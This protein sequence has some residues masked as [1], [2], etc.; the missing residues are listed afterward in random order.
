MKNK[1]KLL[2]VLA[3]LALCVCTVVTGTLAWLTAETETITNTFSPS[4]IQLTL[5]E[6]GTTDNKK[7]FKMI[8]GQELGKDPKIEVKTDIACYV[9]VKI[10]ETGSVTVGSNN[11]SFD[12]FM[13]YVVDG[14]W[15]SLTDVEGVYYRTVSANGTFSVLQDNEIT[16][17][18]T[19]SSEMM[20]AFYTDGV[21]NTVAAPT[22][23]FTA[24]AI[25]QQ[26]FA[27]AT[28]AWAKVSTLG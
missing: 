23:A 21:R 1:K 20:S 4:N 13:S 3:C 17:K 7:E 5:T 14:G 24:Y 10:V 12:D 22:L 28:A 8:P 25:Q 6:T 2:V 27:D 16:I 18:E 11:Y 15:T 19:V 9:F 26:G